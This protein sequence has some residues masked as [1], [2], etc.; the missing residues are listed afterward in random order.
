MGLPSGIGLIINGTQSWIFRFS[1]VPGIW[2]VA[3]AQGEADRD[4]GQV[5]F[6]AQTID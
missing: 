3:F 5:E 1:I 2:V 6:L 4:A